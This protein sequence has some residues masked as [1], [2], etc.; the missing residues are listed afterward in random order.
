MPFWRGE[1]LLAQLPSL[2]PGFN[3]AHIDCA[4][5]TLTLGSDVFVTSD[6]PDVGAPE[7]GVK[8]VLGPQQQIR[9]NP[10][11]FAFLKTQ[12]SVEVPD[13]A[14]AF[15]SMRATF[16]LRGLINVSGFHVDPGW[17]APLLFAVYNAG[18][19]PVVLEQGMPLFLIWYADLDHPTKMTYKG[20]GKSIDAT[21]ISNMSGQVFSPI[22]LQKDV[23]RLREKI[24]QANDAVIAVTASIKS[25]SNLAFRVNLVAL[26]L[27]LTAVSFLF[28]QLMD[29]KLEIAALSALTRQSAAVR[30]LVPEAKAPRVPDA[31]AAKP[32]VK[33]DRKGDARKEKP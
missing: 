30:A 8:T 19:S 18:P 5:Y 23:G 12:E 10:G 32:A 16:K 29:A 25:I 33:Q 28:A 4:A 6:L 24:G 3:P 13:T 9:I 17:K 11:Q 31:A 22:G 7:E 21:L 26:G 20:K 15:I 2:I 27:I 1:T 14:I